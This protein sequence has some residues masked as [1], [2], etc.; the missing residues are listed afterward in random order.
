SYK[1]EGTAYVAFD[2]HRSGDY[3]IYIYI[4]KDYGATFS[5]I[6]NGIP[7]DAGTV[8]V[9][10]EDPANPNLLFAGTEFGLFV[11]FDRGASWTKMKNGLPTVPIFDLQ[12]HPREHDLILATHGRSFWIMDNISALEQINDQTLSADLKLFG[13]RPAVEYRM[14]NYRSF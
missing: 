7:Q 11:S 8:H 14:A 5:R 3:A 13:S 1:E 10:R 6:T 4:T 2:N 12:I 9:V